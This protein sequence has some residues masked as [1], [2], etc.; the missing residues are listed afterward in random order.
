ML[1]F[2]LR[3][4][5]AAV[6]LL[7]TAFAVVSQ[8]ALL[9]SAVQVGIVLALLTSI[10]FGVAFALAWLKRRA[11]FAGEDGQRALK[12]FLVMAFLGL[13]IIWLFWA[14]FTLVM[15]LGAI[16]STWR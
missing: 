16:D 5:L 12:A 1:Q 9:P 10:L 2:R 13:G 7:A 3:T 14:F 4:L 11:E 8:W 6:T 15:F